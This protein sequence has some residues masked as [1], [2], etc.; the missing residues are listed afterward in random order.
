MD[1]NISAKTQAIINIDM[2]FYMNNAYMY[3]YITLSNRMFYGQSFVY[4]KLVIH[5]H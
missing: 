1:S 5:T 4:Y 2:L 3:I